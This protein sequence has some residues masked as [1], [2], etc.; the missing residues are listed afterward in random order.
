MAPAS[1]PLSL[2][3]S[4]KHDSDDDELSKVIVA[5]QRDYPD[6]ENMAAALARSLANSGISLTQES[7]VTADVA[8][9]G[10]P[11]SIST[12]LCPLFLRAAGATVPKLGVPGRPAGGIDCLAQ[13][14]GY[15]VALSGQEAR[16]I[17]RTGGYAHFIAQGELAP[18]DGRMFRLRQTLGAQAVPTLV[19]ASLLA[20]KIAVGVKLAGL[21]VRVSPHGNFGT[22][23]DAA[24]RNSQLFCRSA[25]LLGI[26]AFP[27]L[28]DAR[29]PTQPYLGRKES[30]V[31][32]ADIFAGTT[33]EWLCDHLDVCRSLALA[34]LP[35]HS[36]AAVARVE[37]TALRLRFAQNLRDQ[38]ADI[39]DFDELVRMTRVEHRVVLTADRAG[40]C[41][42]PLS[43]LRDVIVACQKTFENVSVPFPDPVG[44]VFSK[45]P[46]T[47]VKQGES[48]AT[49]RADAAVG[50]DLIDALRRL[51]CTP[52]AMPDGPGLETI[53]E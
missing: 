50:D 31:A 18:L 46:G 32:L 23:W 39:S 10:G 42:Y 1:H 16:D 36:H 26:K 25:R 53:H 37:P 15:R 40:F 8:S 33:D 27:V 45:R 52:A 43:D 38:G 17:L 44:L 9:T 35:E 4:L 49:L 14:P 2:I 22:T 13:I 41:R 24:K 29:H 11:S 6:D 30:L 48:V 51:V 12:L 47:W 5:V 20:K 28:T 34:C 3:E 19:V 7:D 21:D